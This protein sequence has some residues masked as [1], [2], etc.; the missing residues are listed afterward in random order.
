MAKQEQIGIMLKYNVTT[1]DFD[2]EPHTQECVDPVI[3]IARDRVDEL[4]AAPGQMRR[5]ANECMRQFNFEKDEWTN[6]GEPGIAA[7]IY[8]KTLPMFKCMKRD[9]K[10]TATKR[11]CIYNISV[12]KCKCP[13]GRKLGALL[14]PQMYAQNK[15]NTK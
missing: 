7:I 9:D 1:Y 8:L 11:D 6:F 13:I 14:W 15:Q 5:Y 4:M 2:D 12:G 10:K 3:D